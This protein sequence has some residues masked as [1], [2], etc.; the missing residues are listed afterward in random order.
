M[1]TKKFFPL[2]MQST[3]LLSLIHLNANAQSDI[4]KEQRPKLDGRVNGRDSTQRKVVFINYP[5]NFIVST[6]KVSGEF[7]IGHYNG[8]KLIGSFGYAK[9]FNIFYD[10]NGFKEYGLESQFRFY[11]L[12]DRPVLNGFFV[13]PFIAYKSIT[14]Q[15]SNYYNSSQTETAGNFSVGFLMGGQF[16]YASSFTIDAFIGGGINFISGN[17]SGGNLS[18]GIFEYSNGIVFHTG[19]GIGFAH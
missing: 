16:I 12:E 18:S 10:L 13:T 8:L 17:N 14:Y 4:Q 11:V 9:D 2:I 6:M 7:R 5:L 19:I 3:F 1:K 15:L